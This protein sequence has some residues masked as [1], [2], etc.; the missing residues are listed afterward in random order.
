MNDDPVH[1]SVED[2][3]TPVDLPW[4][5]RPELPEDPEDDEDEI[6]SYANEPESIAP[7][8]LA[9]V[10]PPPGIGNK[11]VSNALAIW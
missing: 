5:E 4:W 6:L 1:G 2:N 8:V 11:L 3:I 10:V 7:E 9:G